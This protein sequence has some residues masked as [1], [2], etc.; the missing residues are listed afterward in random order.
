M[1]QWARF[2]YKFAL[3]PVLFTNPAIVPNADEVL[4][5]ETQLLLFAQWLYNDHASSTVV[6]YLGDVKAWHRDRVL[7]V[8]FQA[9][10]VVFFRIPLLFKVFK[11][12]TPGKKRTKLEW[13]F[14]FF[15]QI[16]QGVSGARNGVFGE[17]IEGY[18]QCTVWVMKLVAFQQLMRMNELALTNPPSKADFLPLVWGDVRFIDDSDR[19]I[20]WDMNGRPILPDQ[21]RVTYCLVR[22]PP[23]KMNDEGE[24]DGLA[25][26]FPKNWNG[27]PSKASAAV[28]MW[29]RMQRYPVSRKHAKT[30][31]LFAYNPWGTAEPI[32]FTVGNF[33]T[34]SHKLCRLAIPEIRYTGLG[35]HAYCIGGTNRL[36]DVGATEPQVHAAGRWRS[37]C[38]VLYARR[39]RRVMWDLFRVMM[40][41]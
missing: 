3:Q 23:S 34:T 31:P 17:G 4:E 10:G 35:L 38:W 9:L 19:E 33:Q 27:G 41:A 29:Q 24:E 16:E 13:K 2:C 18:R 36:I 39:N 26:P 20:A 11:R 5:V 30:W 40:E 8:P 14:E 6:R 12:E 21:R 37:D 28:A 7:G 32:K 22:M 1:R 25:F 15:R